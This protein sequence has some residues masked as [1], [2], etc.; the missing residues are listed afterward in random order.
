MSKWRGAYNFAQHTKVDED[1]AWCD[2]E[3][4]EYVTICQRGSVCKCCLREM[5][6]QAREVLS[7]EQ[8]RYNPPLG[9]IARLNKALDG[10]DD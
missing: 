4:D 1:V 2:C 8:R 5:I 9:L 6:K 10:T 7:E 3:S